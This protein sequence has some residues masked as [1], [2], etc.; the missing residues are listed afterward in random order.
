MGSRK[1]IDHSG[2][3]FDNFLEEEGLLEQSEAVAIKRV[4][5]WQLQRAMNQKQV[6]KKHMAERLRTSRTQV[7]RLLNPSYVGVSLEA[8]ARA[9]RA[10]GKRIRIEIVDADRARNGAKSLTRTATRSSR[11]GQQTRKRIRIVTD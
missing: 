3:S 8:V 11:P 5:A 1:I 7:D 6:T 4:I 2:S 10:V 9:A